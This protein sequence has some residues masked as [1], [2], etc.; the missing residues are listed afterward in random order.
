MIP[1]PQSSVLGSKPNIVILGLA[2][3][4]QYVEVINPFLT[5]FSART[6]NDR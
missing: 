1:S 4:I 6:G 2:P 3:G 5:R